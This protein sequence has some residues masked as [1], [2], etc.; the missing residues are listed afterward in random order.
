MRV[1]VNNDAGLASPGLN[2]DPHFGE[3]VVDDATGVALTT[4]T[5][6]TTLGGSPMLAGQSFG[7]AVA[8]AGTITI[9]RA[10]LYLVHFA[11]NQITKVNSQ[12]VTIEVYNNAAVL[13]TGKALK[14]KFTQ[15]ATAVEIPT[16]SSFG[17]LSLAAGDVLTLKGTADT[18]N[19]TIKNLRFGATQL[20]D[21]AV[22]PTT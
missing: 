21:A 22:S 16:M 13:T 5:S 14:A 15:P 1:R 6:A 9:A 17:I 3:L 2:A 8:V 20:T 12:V 11:A 19:L 4:P 10:G 18:G 7:L